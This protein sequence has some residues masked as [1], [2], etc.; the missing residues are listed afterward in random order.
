MFNHFTAHGKLLLSAEYLVLKGSL[1]LAIPLNNG[2]KMKVEPSNQD[3]LIWT[4]NTLNAKWFDVTFDQNFNI[5]KTTNKPHAEKLSQILRAAIE[6]NPSSEQIIKNKSVTTTL[7]FNPQWGWGSSSTLLHLLGQ[8]LQ[9]DPWLLMDQTFGGSGYDI[10]CAGA[11]Q[12]IF[13]KRLPGAMPNVTFA[14]FNPPFLSHLGVVWLNHKQN[15][16]T[17]VKNFLNGGRIDLK[18]IDEI[19]AITIEMARIDDL[20]YFEKLMAEHEQIIG[21]ATGLQPIQKEIFPDFAG[22]IKSLGA[23]GGDFILYACQQPFENCEKYFQTK[24]Y[25]QLFRLEEI[26]LNRNGS[27]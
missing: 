23:W 1:A 6:I 16:S 24:G 9:V 13:Y 12:P 2:Q 22:S 27:V 18:S 4:A 8:W 10:A 11:T 5:L 17:E 14:P 25:N 19:T 3:G 20:S 7:E 21:Q 26:M 15:S